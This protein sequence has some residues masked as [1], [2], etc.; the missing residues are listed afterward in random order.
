MAWSGLRLAGAGVLLLSGL[1]CLE[2]PRSDNRA[3]AS[4][5]RALCERLRCESDPQVIVPLKVPSEDQ[6]VMLRAA[7]W[8]ALPSIVQIRTTNLDRAGLSSASSR[9]R[10]VAAASGGSGVVIGADGLILT[11][12]HVVQGA[13]DT[14]VVLSDG[15]RH[16]V[17][18]AAAAPSLDLAV[19]RIER[20]GLS[21]VA[22]CDEPAGADEPVVAIGHRG[23]EDACT[24]CEGIVSRPVVSL[25]AQLDP[26]RKR[27][28][29][30]L[31]ESSAGIEPGF[32][33][34]PLLDVRGRLVGLNVAAVSDGVG[35]QARGYALPINQ[36][37]KEFIASLA[38]QARA[39]KKSSAP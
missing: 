34:G 10:M 30:Q 16:R 29:A 27:C 38:E 24:F 3:S 2:P 13:C 28:Y 5:W 19:L 17:I 35:S 9:P 31:I 25:Q 15:S 14:V 22:V 37:T 4:Q 32:S 11:N 39:S 8:Q 12:E 20:D 23:L 21:P 7:A 26:T 36:Q 18:C 6:A 1:G 33:G